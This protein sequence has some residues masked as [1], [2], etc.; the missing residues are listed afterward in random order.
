[1]KYGL[2]SDIHANLEAFEATLDA[3][4]EEQVDQYVFLGDIVGYG[5][6]PKACIARLKD[7]V[8]KKGCRYIA[9][10][11]DFAVCGRSSSEYF[12]GYAKEAIKWT[13]NQLDH[14]DM[15]F[16][17]QMKLIERLDGFTAVHATLHA[18]EEW[19]YILDI[20]DAYPN[21]KILEDQICFIGHSH[22]A[23]VFTEGE[24]V[25]WLLESNIEI[26]EGIRYLIN[27]GSVGQPRDGNPKASFAIY[28]TRQKTVDIKR[29]AYDIKKAQEKILGAGLPKMLAK[30]LSM[31]M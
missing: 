6:D 22:K 21:F 9:G 27:I 1:M 13:K 16:L 30:R 26:Q 15:A 29:I 14:A 19:G 4:K 17:S 11:H 7:L 20:D 2:F 24:M 28:D 5:A 23:V 18:P 8:I 31:G 12:N 3:L 10:N 25:D